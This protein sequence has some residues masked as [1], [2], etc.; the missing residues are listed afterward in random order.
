MTILGRW[1]VFGAF[2]TVAAAGLV[3]AAC[4]PERPVTSTGPVAPI[5]VQQ[6]AAPKVAAVSAPATAPIGGFAAPAPGPN[7]LAKTWPER[8][9]IVVSELKPATG[10]A[11]LNPKPGDLW[12]FSNSSTT[13]GATNTKNAV[14]VIDAKTKQ[15]VAEAAPF[16]G[17][18]NSSTASLFQVT[19]DSC[20]CRCS[21]KTIA[22]TSWTGGASKWSRQLPRSDGRTTTSCGTTRSPV[23][24]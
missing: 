7:L 18:G 16:D 6:A 21:A 5:T 17:E 1:H 15:T 8:L 23:K 20:T 11:V 2:A 19:A 24:I 4:V 12:F 9:G 22:S 14:W 3:A 13:W 10:K